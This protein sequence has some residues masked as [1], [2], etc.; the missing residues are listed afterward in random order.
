MTL[1]GLRGRVAVITGGASGI[2]R[3][4]AE[5]FAT[6]GARLVLA[7]VE[8]P[9]LAAAG[10]D[11]RAAGAEVAEVVT[12]VADPGAVDALADAAYQRFGAVHV[13]STTPASSAP[14]RRGSSRSRTGSGCSA[15]TCGV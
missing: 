1:D 14:G 9:A 15:S 12:D 11:L 5:R 10:A 2:G 7:D 6:A 8:E 4:L 13:V 3:A